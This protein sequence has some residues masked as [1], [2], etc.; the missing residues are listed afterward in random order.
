MATYEFWLSSPLGRRM[1]LIDKFIKMDCTRVANDIGALSLTLPAIYDTYLAQDNIIEIWRKPIDSSLSLFN[2]YLIR[3]WDYVDSLAGS[4]T[5]ITGLDG[6]DLLNR[7]IVAY[8]AGSTSTEMT[9]AA[10]DLMKTIVS[11]NCCTA[12]TDTDRDWSSSGFTVAANDTAGQSI[13]M[14]FSYRNVLSICQDLANASREAG[15]RVYFDVRPTISSTEMITWDFRTNINQPGIDHTG[16]DLVTFG[17]EWGNLDNPML[18]YDYTGEATV[19]YSGGAGSEAERVV[20]EV[21]NTTRSKVSP[22]GRI[23]KFHNCAGQA[24]D[25]AAVYAAGQA[26]LSANLPRVRFN[27]LLKDGETTRLG[28]D[29]DY[30]DKVVITYRGKQIDAVINAVQLTVY[31]NGDEVI[32]GR[33][34]VV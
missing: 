23:E 27:G 17:L 31:G 4:E 20:E 12:A 21:E 10:D 34:E 9:G 3:G 7:R 14:G 6:N 26:E 19:I 30:G 29:W 11:E 5:H 28:K 22:W 18:S 33:F 8:A 13:T 24:S 1:K 32:N 2:A 25:T 16:N 15:T